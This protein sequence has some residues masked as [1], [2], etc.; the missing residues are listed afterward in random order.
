MEYDDTLH[1]HCTLVTM[2]AD[3]MTLKQQTCGDTTIGR[4]R[5]T[6]VEFDPSWSRALVAGRRVSYVAE[7]KLHGVVGAPRMDTMHDPHHSR[8]FTLPCGMGM[9]V[10]CGLGVV[11]RL[12]QSLFEQQHQLKKRATRNS[13]PPF[14]LLTRS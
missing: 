9:G 10:V 12:A 2:V 13:G 1:T 6:P 4:L 14:L 5:D 3:Y 8:A 11:R 7:R